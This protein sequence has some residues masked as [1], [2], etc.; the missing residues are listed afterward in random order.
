MSRVL[1]KKNYI[2]ISIS[3]VCV[4]TAF[5]ANPQVYMI[6]F[7]NGLM[8]WAT[9]LLPS[10][11]PFL[12]FTKLL[13][14]L[15]VVN[16]ITQNFKFFS[17]VYNV[18]PIGFYAFFMSILSGY[19]VGAKVVSDLC[20]SGMLGKNDAIKVCTFT[21]NSGPM[22]I[23]GTVGLGLLCSKWLG[24]ILLVSHIFGALLNGLVYRNHKAKNVQV[25]SFTNIQKPAN[26]GECMWDSIVSILVIGGFVCIFFVVIDI[27][28]NLGIFVFLA[29]F[30]SGVFGVEADIINSIL[31]GVVEMTHGCLDITALNMDIF[32]VAIICEALITFG[33]F[34]TMFQAYAFLQKIGISLGFFIKQKLSQTLFACLFCGLL[35]MIFI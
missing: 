23:Y 21:S 29:N 22:F 8:V 3:L 33:G 19:P 5:V 14:S 35:V 4:L 24:I 16:S 26:L 13:T 6:S 9:I 10:I 17:K 25:S 2:L 28:N 11:F 18:P 34:A 32:P 1:M 30:L 7:S 12:F 31:N 15:G 27:L 20:A